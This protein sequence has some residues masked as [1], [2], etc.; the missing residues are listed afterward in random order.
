MLQ[1][2]LCVRYLL[3]CL[4]PP[5]NK[6]YGDRNCCHHFSDGETEA[7]KEEVTCPRSF[8]EWWH[9]D[10]GTCTLIHVLRVLRAENT[11]SLSV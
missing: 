2:L 7:H 1:H 6:A 3:N 11:P 10:L 5:H 8:S 9:Q 4:Y